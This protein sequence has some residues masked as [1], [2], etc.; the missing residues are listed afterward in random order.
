MTE[1][2]LEKYAPNDW[3]TLIIP[4]DVKDSLIKISEQPNFRLLLYGSPGTGKTSVIKILSKGASLQYL[5][6]SNDFNIEV[7][8]NKVYAF[9][10]G[11]SV[12]YQRKICAIDEFENMRDNL[13]DALKVVLDQAKNVSFIFCTNEI[14]KVNPAIRSRCTEINFDFLNSYLSECKTLYT[15]WVLNIVK[16]L[17]KE[18]ILDYDTEGLKLLIKQNFPGYRKI[19][20]ILQQLIDQKQSINV[21]SVTDCAGDGK[22]LTELYEMIM[23]NKLSNEQVYTEICKYRSNEKDSLMSLCEPFFKYLN[24]KQMY[25]KT[26]EVSVIM[27]KYCNSFI[28]SL[29]KFNTFMSCIVELKTLFR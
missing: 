19:L 21:R 7:M 5:S 25:D 27:D 11:A 24:D 3:S 26:L 22:T 20:V 10:S 13:Q 9:A 12:G 14:Q 15:T 4:K 18:N 17:K 28:T 29:N 2:L 23:N 8:R 6:A 16:E 1:T